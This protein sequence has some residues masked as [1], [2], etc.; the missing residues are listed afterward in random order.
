ME[1]KIYPELEE[2]LQKNPHLRDAIFKE[3]KDGKIDFQLDRSK[4]ENATLMT[5]IPVKIYNLIS[6]RP[7]EIQH[8]F[9]MEKEKPNGISRDLEL[10]QL[11]IFSLFTAGY[12]ALVFIR[13]NDLEKMR[14]DIQKS[15]PITFRCLSIAV[16]N[17]TRIIRNSL[18]HGTFKIER[19][20]NIIRFED[21]IANTH[22]SISIK[23]YL[24]LIKL[25]TEIYYGIA[26]LNL[27]EY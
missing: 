23:E 21:R 6:D 5:S 25:I 26:L 3:L 14:C 16:N 12:I 11:L 7:K 15:C 4:L 22:I 10:Q 19:E 27:Q 8:L 2:L 20:N 18:A 13:S 17:S 1:N 24:D 9:S